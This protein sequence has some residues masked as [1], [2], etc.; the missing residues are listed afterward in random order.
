MSWI[1]KEKELPMKSGL[2]LVNCYIG[3]ENIVKPMF[4]YKTLNIKAQFELYHVTHWQEL[5]SP[6]I[7]P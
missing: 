2:I 6:V 7:F 1:D 5:P 4:I 3:L